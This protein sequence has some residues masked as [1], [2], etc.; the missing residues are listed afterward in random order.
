[1]IRTAAGIGV[2]L[3]TF[4]AAA[5]VRG[6]DGVPVPSGQTVIFHEIVRDAAGPAGLTYR[7]R[8]V[9]PGIARDGG[10]VDFE[11]AAADMDHLCQD[12]ALPRI[13]DLGPRPAQIVISL[14]DRA[15]EFGVPA[16]EVTQF[17]EAYRVED[18]TCIWEGF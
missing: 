14:A 9:A 15:V 6:Q 11:T 2:A 8:F 13:S 18:G 16:P 4:S 17:F 5:S 10:T 1:M 3:A 7:F 12:F